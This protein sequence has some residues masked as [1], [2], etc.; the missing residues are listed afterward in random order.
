MSHDPVP[1]IQA[2]VTGT[3]ALLP[4]ASVP[5]SLDSAPMALAP[6][7]EEVP[8]Y[9]SSS[10]IGEGGGARMGPLGDY[11][12]FPDENLWGVT[13]TIIPAWSIPTG[14]LPLGFPE[15]R[16]TPVPRRCPAHPAPWL[17]LGPFG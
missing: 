4:E 14:S 2:P 12:D 17:A 6:V 10:L 5:D 8:D 1:V 9:R 7:P 16:E 3:P 15:R 11:P 13:Q